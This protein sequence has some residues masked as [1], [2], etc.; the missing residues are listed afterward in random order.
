MEGKHYRGWRGSR[1]KQNELAPEQAAR[2][3]IFGHRLAS[4]ESYFW[5]RRSQELID[6]V[7]KKVDLSICQQDRGMTIMEG[8]LTRS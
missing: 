8:V 3:V 6:L 5:I 1:G 7:G 4:E 2:K